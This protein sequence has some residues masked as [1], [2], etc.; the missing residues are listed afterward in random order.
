MRKF[1]IKKGN[2]RRKCFGRYQKNEGIWKERNAKQWNK[3]KGIQRFK[4]GSW[5]K[6]EDS[7]NKNK[8]V[9]LQNQKGMVAV[10]EMQEGN[11]CEWQKAV[12]QDC[13][14]I[15]LSDSYNPRLE[16]RAFRG[17]DFQLSLHSWQTDR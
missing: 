1:Q 11:G 4:L 2:L 14:P 3:T 6:S 12:E 10:P 7:K 9:Q 15:G 16:G 5:G 17:P 13:F 8:F